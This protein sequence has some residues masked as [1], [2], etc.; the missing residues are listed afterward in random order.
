MTYKIN[1]GK[2]SGKLLKI[3]QSTVETAEWINVFGKKTNI[4]GTIGTTIATSRA[5]HSQMSFYSYSSF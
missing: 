2:K 1:I 3:N 5:F 4:S